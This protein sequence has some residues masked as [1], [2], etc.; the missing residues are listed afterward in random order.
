M[1]H[2]PRAATDKIRKPRKEINTHTVEMIDQ[3]K[4]R[5][6]TNIMLQIIIN[7]DTDFF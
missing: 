2:K 7:T 5:H 4:K 6:K 1:H 3:A